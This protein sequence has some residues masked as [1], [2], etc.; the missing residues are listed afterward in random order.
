LTAITQPDGAPRVQQAPDSDVEFA[1]ALREAQEAG[2]RVEIAGKGLRLDVGNPIAAERRLLTTR[3]DRLLDYQ[4]DDMTVTAEAGMTL[5]DLQT[6]LAA[7]GQRLALDPAHPERT[8][9]GGLV[10]ASPDGPWRSG[11]GTV[12]DQLIGLTV[13]A[14][15]GTL[16]KA[17]SRVV[18]HV[19][20][21]DLPKLFTGS[22]GTLGAIV[23]TSWRVRPLPVATG[24]I[25]GHWED[26]AALET[27]WRALRQ[28]PLEPTFFE[29]GSDATGGFLAMGF[30]GEPAAVAWQQ[31]A[32][33]ALV[34]APCERHE[35]DLRTTLAERA[36]AEHAP[37]LV[38]VG[39]PPLE[40]IAFLAA[41]RSDLGRD[42]VWTG[43]AANGILYASFLAADGWEVP[44]G[45]A[46]VEALR[47]EAAERKGYL[48]VLRAPLAWKEGWD[49]WG[50]TRADFPLMKAV[51]RAF[52]P[53]AT[54]APGR[55]VG[56]L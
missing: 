49:V 13:A 30:E 3:L 25:Q 5:A 15:D 39:L 48:V 53:R 21:Y 26:L 1:L 18:K 2:E 16:F 52:D 42:A 28:A 14:P 35:D 32:F 44:A 27:A 12:R 8:T 7:H 38:K 40:A 33:E 29:V 22:Y 43:H 34:K 24:A 20:G 56:G 36:H 31:T 55:F 46:L 37:L 17:G 10:A 23:Q 54:L 51:K 6:V 47:R 19:A 9:L 50:P 11:F 45:R 41:I 4:P